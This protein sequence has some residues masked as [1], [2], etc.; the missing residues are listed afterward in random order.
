MKKKIKKTVSF[1]PKE[2]GSLPRVLLLDCSEEMFRMLR[3]SGFQV[4]QG[5]S[6]L[7]DGEREIPRDSSEVEIIFWDTDRIKPEHIYAYLYST[8]KSS[9]SD[10]LR[11][12]GKTLRIFFDQIMRKGG[13][14]SVFLGNT[15]FP[16]TDEVISHHLGLD[17]GNSRG[18]RI[19]SRYTHRVDFLRDNEKDLFIPFFS[20]F[21]KEKKLNFFIEWYSNLA[22]TQFYFKDE[23]NNKYAVVAWNKILISP[24]IDNL[25]KAALFLLQ[26]VL[27]NICDENIY[28]DLYKYS[29]LKEE[30]FKFPEIKKI[31]KKIQTIKREYLNKIQ[32]QKVEL[33]EKI[34]ELSYLYEMLYKD[35]SP[36]FPKGERLKDVIKKI[37]KED[38]GFKKVVDI[39]KERKKKGLALK[40]DLRIGD[41]NFI[42]VKGTETGAKANWIKDLAKHV[43]HYCIAN[44][45]NLTEIKQILI[46]N[47]ERRKDPRE[48][49]KPFANDPELLKRCEE[50]NISL[51]PVFELFKVVIDF[52]NNKLSQKTAQKKLLDSKGLF[53]Y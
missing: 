16:N 45:I 18:F 46:F 47:H 22:N 27:P 50:D 14:I 8:I 44:K 39:D 10:N 40:E 41:N 32:K 2:R 21:T 29:W 17:R 42:E 26:D 31:E 33:Q 20:Q 25:G 19:K 12:S 48:R 51:I 5:K 6:G 3:N 7:V 11:I 30:F 34:E 53:V 36:L 15:V 1:I 52:K 38:L 24:K 4:F 43:N 9:Q 49:S 35:D 13:F 23:D 37:L 28:P